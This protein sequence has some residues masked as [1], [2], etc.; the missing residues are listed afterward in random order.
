VQTEV[1]QGAPEDWEKAINLSFILLAAEAVI[2]GFLKREES[3][4]AHYRDDAAEKK[5]GMEKEHLL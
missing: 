4:G 2:K 1:F 5:K 3:C